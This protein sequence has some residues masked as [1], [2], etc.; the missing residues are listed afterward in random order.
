MASFNSLATFCK[1]QRRLCN[2]ISLW[3]DSIHLRFG[4]TD[5]GGQQ[6]DCSVA[7]QKPEEPKCAPAHLVPRDCSLPLRTFAIVQRPRPP[8]SVQ[9]WGKYNYYRKSFRLFI[10]PYLPNQFNQMKLLQVKEQ[11]SVVVQQFWMQLIDQMSGLLD[12]SILH[13][14]PYVDAVLQCEQLHGR[15]HASLLLKLFGGLLEALCKNRDFLS[16][17]A[18]V[19]T[20]GHPYLSPNNPLSAYSS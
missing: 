4:A 13:S 2:N 18:F 16:E 5:P 6:R 3:K 9:I 15:F 14:L 1:S 11:V 19:S 7:S 17:L 12:S 10:H 20:T 8:R